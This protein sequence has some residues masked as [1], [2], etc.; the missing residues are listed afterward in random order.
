MHKGNE[1]LRDLIGRYLENRLDPEE[2]DELWKLLPVHEG[3]SRSLREEL[4][5]LWERTSREQG[6]LPDDRWDKQISEL[7]R[8]EI[9]NDQQSHRTRRLAARRRRIW[10]AAASILVLVGA[11]LGLAYFRGYRADDLSQADVQQ[12]RIIPGSNRAFLTLAGGRKISLDSLSGGVILGQNG[13][14]ILNLHHGQL[15]YYLNSNNAKSSLN[16]NIL[17]TPR[18][19]QYQLILSDGT[20]VWMNAA[21][22][23][24]YPVVFQGDKRVVDLE[25]EAYFEVAKDAERPFEVQVGRMRVKVLGTRFNIKAYPDEHVAKTTLVSGAVKVTEG[26]AEVR[27]K[28]GQ[29]AKVYRKGAI[30]LIP[31]ADVEAAIAWKNNLFWFDNESIGSIMRRIGRW[32]NV[33]VE[34]KGNVSQHFTGSLARSADVSRVFKLLEETGAVHFKIENRKIIVTP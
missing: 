29:E 23:L 10:W 28:P 15:A 1:H 30:S 19:G 27:L 34:I 20:K 33:D 4:Q 21:S 17:T 32:Y 24:R 14:R 12:S 13:A 26:E 2:F 8:S 7:L 9:P 25:G 22:S 6:G 16:Y 5:A 3:A 18:G 11:G 31:D